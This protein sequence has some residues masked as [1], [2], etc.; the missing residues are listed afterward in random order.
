MK[1]QPGLRFHKRKKKAALPLSQPAKAPADMVHRSHVNVVLRLRPF[2]PEEVN[3]NCTRM[4]HKA[5]S[6]SSDEV[7]QLNTSPKKFFEFDAVLDE[8]QNQKD[9]YHK[10]GAYEAVT[11]DLFRGYNTTIL[12]YGQSGSGKTFTMGTTGLTEE[13]KTVLNRESGVILRAC[14]DLF[15]CVGKICDGNALVEMRYLEVYNEDIRDLLT[16]NPTNQDIQIRETMGGEVFVQGLRKVHVTNALQVGEL[17]NEANGRRVVAPTSINELSSRSH[18]ICIISIKGTTTNEK[19]KFRSRLTLVDLAGSERLVKTESIGHRRTEGININRGLFVLGQVISALTE[20][21]PQFKRLPPFRESKLTRLLQNSLGGNSRTIMIACCS[22]SNLHTEETL[23]TLRYAT[24]TRSIENPA[25]ANIIVDNVPSQE[26]ISLRNENEDLK[27]ENEM[28]KQKLSD[29]QR[30]IEQ[31]TVE[32]TQERSNSD[33]T[34]EEIS[35]LEAEATKKENAEKQL[36]LELTQVR[37]NFH[38]AMEEIAAMEA[39][40]AKKEE[41]ERQMILE[42]TQVRSKFD[43]AMEEIAVMKAV[44]AK[45]EKEEKQRR[46][47]EIDPRRPAGT[48]TDSVTETT[49]SE[50]T[51]EPGSASDGMHTP[52]RTAPLHA[53]ESNH[54]NFASEKEQHFANFVNGAHVTSPSSLLEPLESMLSDEHPAQSN[55]PR[56]AEESPTG[57]NNGSRKP[58]EE[59]SSPSGSNNNSTWRPSIPSFDGNSVSCRQWPSDDEEKAEFQTTFPYR[60]STR[61]EVNQRKLKSMKDVI[62]DSDSLQAEATQEDSIGE[63]SSQV[64]RRKRSTGYYRER[65]LSALNCGSGTYGNHCT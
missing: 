41:E 53:A 18:A 27:E 13:S 33:E 23:N 6:S 14:V 7:V 40:I 19:V 8:A 32:L 20:K 48:L 30:T 12:A 29:F 35:L 64:S 26:V 46:L 60:S 63:Q 62:S 10:S 1:I 21:R 49:Y 59:Q 45:K 58:K 24:K 44:A 11:N 54:W 61:T 51:S 39:V 47:I 57:G 22:P 56:E 55:I 42:L 38:T 5:R 31:M 16:E 4:V 15:D 2:S 9:V 34:K 3:R 43:E 36:T 37:S 28:L 50:M 65:W 25:T 52:E 17:I